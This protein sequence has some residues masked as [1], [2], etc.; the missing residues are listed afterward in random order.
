MEQMKFKT[1]EVIADNEECTDFV[2]VDGDFFTE[3]DV[4]FEIDDDLP[5][6]IDKDMLYESYRD[7]ELFNTKTGQPKKKNR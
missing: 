3:D 7:R 5:E 1:P 6:I 2:L 4:P